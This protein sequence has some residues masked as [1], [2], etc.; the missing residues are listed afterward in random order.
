MDIKTKD[1]KILLVDGKIATAQPCCCNQD[2]C[3]CS[4][5]DIFGRP[6]APGEGVMAHVNF[7]G[8]ESGG[9]W[10]G[11]TKSVYST[12]SYNFAESIFENFIQEHDISNSSRNY[13]R[14][15]S[16]LPQ[17]SGCRWT[18]YM[19]RPE[20]C[21]IFNWLGSYEERRD[22]IWSFVIEDG[23]AYLYCTRYNSYCDHIE[24]L[25]PRHYM[26][27]KGRV[28][29]ICTNRFV[30]N[31]DSEYNYLGDIENDFVD[32][33]YLDQVTTINLSQ[34]I[35]IVTYIPYTD[36]N[37]PMVYSGNT[38]HMSVDGF[39]WQDFGPSTVDVAF[40][41]EGGG[42]YSG[43]LSKLDPEDTSLCLPAIGV[44]DNEIHIYFHSLIYEGV[45]NE[46][47][48]T[49]LRVRFEVYPYGTGTTFCIDGASTGFDLKIIS[50]VHIEN[51][52]GATWD[53]TLQGP[54]VSPP[55]DTS[56]ISNT[57]PGVL[58]LNGGAGGVASCTLVVS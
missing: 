57:Y 35:A 26:R 5:E 13:L 25:N 14:F 53:G 29:N 3:S 39:T 31:F 30:L 56:E 22:N 10:V 2:Q 52:S 40:T 1:Q 33:E 16:G 32:W 20:E 34:S 24:S 19:E 44:F 36:P 18:T 43:T 11:T 27:W 42:F 55:I 28:G 7:L 38:Y 51:N 23:F 4:F 9:P 47:P 6:K 50:V 8:L 41:L 37:L 15:L 46:D 49:I 54:I 58:V 48:G 21:A 45:S 17:E 12:V